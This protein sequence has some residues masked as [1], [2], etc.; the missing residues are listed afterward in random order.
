MSLTEM[1]NREITYAQALLEAVQQEMEADPSVYVFGL[2]VDDP[3]GMYGTTKDLHKKFG[4]HRNFDTPISED[5]MT[6]VAIGSALAGMRPIHVHQRMD[7]LLLCMNQLINVASKT[8]YMFGGEFSV[9]IVVRGIV[10]RSWGQGAQHSQSLQSL[11]MHIPGIK[12]VAPV[13]PY[14]AKGIMIS[15]IR[16]NNPVVILEHR[17][18]YKNLGHVPKESYE[19][20]FGSARS[21]S[22]GKDITIVAISHMVIEAME[23]MNL[24]KDKGITIDLIDPVS[25]SPLDIGSI[26]SSV[27][28]T[29]KLLVVDNGWTSCGASA[30]IIT[31]VIEN[32]DNTSNY[33][34]DRLGFANT[35]CPT[36]K[37]LET[38]FY[39]NAQSIAKK[40]YQLLTGLDDWNPIFKENKAVAKFKGPF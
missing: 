22:E 25:L 14:D 36:T 17:M 28:K 40:A 31:Q 8:S 32:L 24:L 21:L 34:F 7:F 20:P 30:E 12:V 29:G 18:L 39:P 2:G 5:S 6:G 33:K 10:G 13:T 37:S 19:L 11:F 26:V 1:D 4:A 9:P 23:A 27:E 35:P 3:I 38:L 15:S 16:D